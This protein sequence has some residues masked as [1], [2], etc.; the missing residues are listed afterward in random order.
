MGR[1]A[2]NQTAVTFAALGVT[3]CGLA[4]S[5]E[6]LIAARFVGSRFI[7]FTDAVVV[8]FLKL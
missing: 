5:M 8:T 2:A 4:N 7:G 6:M 3:A 1:R